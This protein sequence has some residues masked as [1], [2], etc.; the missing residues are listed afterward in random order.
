MPFRVL[1]VNNDKVIPCG[2]QLDNPLPKTVTVTIQPLYCNMLDKVS[3]TFKD[4]LV[5]AAMSANGEEFRHQRRI[6]NASQSHFRLDGSD[7]TP[8][9]VTPDKH[10]RIE[11]HV[12]LAVLRGADVDKFTQFAS[13]QMKNGALGQIKLIDVSP[14]SIFSAISTFLLN[15][16]LDEFT[17][18]KV[19]LDH[20]FILTAERNLTEGDYVVYDKERDSPSNFTM[21]LSYADGMLFA[22]KPKF[23]NP[24]VMRPDGS[25]IVMRPF[26]SFRV[27]RH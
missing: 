5:V 22:P 10:H 3:I 12:L 2:P 23:R 27:R 14:L 25:G 8:L 19:I 11:F 24:P 21:P 17:K 7:S 4:D 16:L 13:E 15:R 6:E 9:E 18:T 1:K 26:L 20:S